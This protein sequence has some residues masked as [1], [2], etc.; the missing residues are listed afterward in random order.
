MGHIW[1]NIS[2]LQKWFTLEK[3]GHI[4][5]NGSHLQKWVKLQKM[6][7]L[8]KHGSHWQKWVTFYFFFTFWL[9]TTELSDQNGRIAFFSCVS[10]KKYLHVP[11]TLRSTKSLL[12]RAAE[13]ADVYR[14]QPRSDPPS[15]VSKCAAL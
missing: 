4:W 9:I 6:R 13:I 12:V 8:C 15:T 7:H 1:S 10:N 3:L 11:L 2:H 14:K 5:R